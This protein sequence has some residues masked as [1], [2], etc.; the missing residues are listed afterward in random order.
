MLRL[1]GGNGD[2]G[3]SLWR[4]DYPV[5][6]G[7]FNEWIIVCNESE[8]LMDPLGEQGV[9]Q[10]RHTEAAS[11]PE[12]MGSVRVASFLLISE[13]KRRRKWTPK[14]YKNSIKK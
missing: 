4:L 10:E 5:Y 2:L 7:L 1:D 3:A 12:P 11:H 14:L 13:P 6:S 9:P 8:N